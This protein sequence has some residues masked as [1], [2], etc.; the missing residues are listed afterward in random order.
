MYQLNAIALEAYKKYIL[1]NLIH[2][3]QVILC[4]YFT[5]VHLVFCL[6]SDYILF[7]PDPLDVLSNHGST[8]YISCVLFSLQALISLMMFF[9][10]L[11][12]L[13]SLVTVSPSALLQQLRGT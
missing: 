6:G 12:Y 10:I 4:F 5:K 3:G 11:F 9:L 13:C 7:D 1:V 2:S 8:S